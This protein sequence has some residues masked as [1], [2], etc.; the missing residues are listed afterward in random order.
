MRKDTK[1]LLVLWTRINGVM[2][3]VRG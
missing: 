3:I 1:K 2:T